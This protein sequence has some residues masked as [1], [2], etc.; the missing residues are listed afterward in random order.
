MAIIPAPAWGATRPQLVV[1]SES[2]FNPRSRV[3]SDRPT[4]THCS[5]ISNVKLSANYLKHPDY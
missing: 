4:I 3:G 1:P 2:R 5:A